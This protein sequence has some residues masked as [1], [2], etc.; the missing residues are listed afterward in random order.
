M[1]TQSDGSLYNLLTMVLQLLIISDVILQT[2]I[3]CLASYQFGDMRFSV[4]CLTAS[5]VHLVSSQ[6]LHHG[7]DTS[8]TVSISTHLLQKVLA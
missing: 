4:A 2:A 8:F 1:F 6:R 3:R 7:N 5:Q